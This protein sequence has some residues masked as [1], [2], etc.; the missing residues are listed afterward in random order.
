M[1]ITNPKHIPRL[2]DRVS[3]IREQ[4]IDL[5]Y[6]LIVAVWSEVLSDISMNLYYQDRK[7]E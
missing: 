3:I 2:D 7:Q 5:P 6:H 4:V 1:S